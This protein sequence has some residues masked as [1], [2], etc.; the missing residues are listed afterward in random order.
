MLRPY[1]REDAALA[2]EIRHDVLE[3]ILGLAPGRVR[4]RVDHG[5]VAVTGRIDSAT[6]LPVIVRLCE[7]VAGVVAVRPRLTCAYGGAD[8]DGEPPRESPSSAGTTVG[9]EPT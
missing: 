7:S 8:L 9:R 6:D 5:V 2:D 3:R 1:L 4:V